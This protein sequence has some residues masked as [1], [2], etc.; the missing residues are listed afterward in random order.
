MNKVFLFLA[1]AA[2]FVACGPKATK[3]EAEPI[4]IDEEVIFDEPTFEDDSLTVEIDSIAVL[5]IAE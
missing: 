5:E 2:V 1:V 4:Q 3:V